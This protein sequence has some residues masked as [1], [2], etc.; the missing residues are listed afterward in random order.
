MIYEKRSRRAARVGGGV[1]LAL[2]TAAFLVSVP[3]ARGQE[4]AS[5]ETKANPDGPG[6]EKQTDGSGAESEKNRGGQTNPFD[7]TDAPSSKRPEGSAGQEATPEQNQRSTIEAR[8][9]EL[10]TTMEKYHKQLLMKDSRI[11]TLQEQ[12]NMLTRRVEDLESSLK[13]VRK[14]NQ[15]LQKQADR[16][17]TKMREAESALSE[18]KEKHSSM[19]EKFYDIQKKYNH[20]LSET[21]EKEQRIQALK[22][23]LNEDSTA[24]G[25]KTTSDDEVSDDEASSDPPSDGEPS[26]DQQTAEATSSGPE[27]EPAQQDGSSDENGQQP[28][29]SSGKDG[30]ETKRKMAETFHRG[31][32]ITTQRGTVVTSLYGKHGVKEGMILY[33]VTDGEVVAELK[34]TAVYNKE[35]DRFSFTE[36]N[37]RAALDRIGEG[38]RVQTMP[39]GEAPDASG[40]SSGSENQD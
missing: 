39:P 10:L 21:H 31:E 5:E 4:E 13:T 7:G 9:T 32:V 35:Q 11:Q 23:R 24:S 37:Q 14:R 28:A 29:K 38:M 8:L 1:L 27:N 18:L 40:S 20:L 36:P 12:V 3:L 15:E 26:D 6:V 16:Y 19:N 30:S 33:A 34:V 2:I 22:N 17:R 25:S